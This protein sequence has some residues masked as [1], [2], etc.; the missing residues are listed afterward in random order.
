M[1]AQASRRLGS[2][3]LLRGG[4]M[5]LMVLDHARY[6]LSDAQIDPTDAAR[7]TLPLFL[8]R[9]VTHVCAPVFVLL[10]GVGARLSLARGR[11]VRSLSGFLLTRGLWLVVLELT[12]ARRDRAAPHLALVSRHDE[13]PASTPPR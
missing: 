1:N 2:V 4:V 12:L 7:T 10:A 5:L 8:T 3:D 13:V 11:T 6:F 9:W